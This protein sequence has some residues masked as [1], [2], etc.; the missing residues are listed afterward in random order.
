MRVAPVSGHDD[1]PESRYRAPP[2][3]STALRAE[4]RQNARLRRRV[5]EEHFASEREGIIRSE[6]AIQVAQVHEP[7][8]IAQSAAT[9]LKERLAVLDDGCAVAI[10]AAPRLLLCD[11]E[12]APLV[13]RERRSLASLDRRT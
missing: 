12:C 5:F 3:D 9:N 10:Y 11:I 4:R 1:R 2:R 13:D 7:A 8:C 6:V